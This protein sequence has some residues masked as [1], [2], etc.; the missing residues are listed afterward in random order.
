[1][2]PR[3]GGG[4]QL[5]WDSMFPPSSPA[6]RVAQPSNPDHEHQHLETHL[7]GLDGPN[8]KNRA[9]S[10][11][12]SFDERFQHAPSGN[13]GN[14]HFRSPTD[15]AA[16]LTTSAVNQPLTPGLGNAEALLLNDY[17]DHS[18]FGLGF[19]PPQSTRSS[20][21][22]LGD[23]PSLVEYLTDTTR[24]VTNPSEALYAPVQTEGYY[25][26]LA[27]AQQVKPASGTIDFGYS[28]PEAPVPIVDNGL[29]LQNWDPHG[30]LPSPDYSSQEAQWAAHDN[31]QVCFAGSG[32]DAGTVVHSGIASTLVPP[33]QPAYPDQVSLPPSNGHAQETLFE[34]AVFPQSAYAN[35][36]GNNPGLYPA[37]G[38]TP[39]SFSDLPNGDAPR[40]THVDADLL[41]VGKG[42]DVGDIPPGFL[43]DLTVA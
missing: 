18:R 12:H 4:A 23:P 5:D 8:S 39:Q 15:A 31:Q 17:Q 34:S 24:T 42:G 22:G 14:T 26:P 10:T 33:G 3:F 40:G 6:T 11:I 28:V 43:G 13:H 38:S 2:G 29:E 7:L 9:K 37:P 32:G 36:S 21:S 1:M 20:P 30:T 25:Q 41:H 27:P 19:P 35:G 16:L